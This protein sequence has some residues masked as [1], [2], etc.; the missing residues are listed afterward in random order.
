MAV[1]SKPKGSGAGDRCRTF[2]LHPRD[3]PR[4]VTFRLMTS[5]AFRVAMP[6]VVA[7]RFVVSANEPDASF[8]TL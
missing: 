3:S 5:S 1:Y 2:V 8:V 4:S 7:L 6:M